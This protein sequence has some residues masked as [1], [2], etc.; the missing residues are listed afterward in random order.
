MYFSE[1]HRLGLRFTPIMSVLVGVIS[2]LLIIALVV[3]LVLRLQHG[4]NNERRKH[5]KNM[6]NS[7]CDHRGS[8]SGPTLSDK[9][10]MQ[11]KMKWKE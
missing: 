4:S 3:I 10:G 11:W 8:V 7:G 2:A 5:N 6:R 1:T 9:G